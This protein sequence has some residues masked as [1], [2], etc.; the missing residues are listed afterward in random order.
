MLFGSTV[1]PPA[2]A[3]GDLGLLLHVEMNELARMRGLN[4]SDDPATSALEVRESRHPVARPD[5]VERRGRKARTPSQPSCTHLVPA[6]QLDHPALHLGRSLGGATPRPARTILERRSPTG[7]VAPP[8]LVRRLTRDPH[9]LGGRCHRPAVFDQAAQT[10]STFRREWSVTV[11]SE[12]PWLCG[13]VN[14]STLPRGLTSS[15]DFPRQQGPWAEHLDGHSPLVGR[16]WQKRFH[17]R[18]GLSLHGWEPRHLAVQQ[19]ATRF[20]RP[21]SCNT[22][23]QTGANR[24]R[25]EAGLPRP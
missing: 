8:P 6:P 2:A 14:S 24:E 9:R 10:E 15:G 23:R 20:L 25:G 19:R 3:F 12:P 4:A 18:L 13:C 22:Q 5:G 11:H 21:T 16:Y 1:H 17:P 7:Q